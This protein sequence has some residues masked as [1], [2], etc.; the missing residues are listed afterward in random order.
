MEPAHCLA[1]RVE[2]RACDASS[3]PCLLLTELLAATAGGLDRDADAPDQVRG[4][5]SRWSSEEAAAAGI[6]LLPSVFERS[7]DS[8]ASDTVLRE[9]LGPITM[10]HYDVVKRF[11]L[12]TYMRVK[13]GLRPTRRRSR[14]WE[15]E[16]YLEQ[17]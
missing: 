16:A 17:I 6:E 12:A 3:D 9:A 14:T 7:L 10:E 8:P 4:D 15:R 2:Y 11:E 1:R 13:A 5:P